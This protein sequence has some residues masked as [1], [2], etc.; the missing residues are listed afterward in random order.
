MEY[1][2]EPT[3]LPAQPTVARRA[4]LPIDRVGPWLAESYALIVEFL[5]RYGQPIVGPPY[6]WYTFVGTKADVEAG[7][8]VGTSVRPEGDIV[9]SVLPAVTAAVT[10][11]VG[12]YELLRDAYK[13]VHAWITE[14]DGEPSD[15][16]WEIYHDDPA[17]QPDSSRW[18]TDVVVPYRPR[19]RGETPH[20]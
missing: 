11:H 16:H 13:A 20:G 18:R 14:Q 1:I 5:G 8:P 12:S 9:A 7:F 15:G 19:G 3:Q 4:L 2:V 17:R 6:A 10:T